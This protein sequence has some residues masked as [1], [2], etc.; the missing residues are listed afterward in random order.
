MWYEEW[1]RFH[2]EQTGDHRVNNENNAVGTKQP[3]ETRLWSSKVRSRS[4]LKSSPR[5]LAL[6]TALH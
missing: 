4:S 3:Y 2:Q 5:Y 1:L 6:R